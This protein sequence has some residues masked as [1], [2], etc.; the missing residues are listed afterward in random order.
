MYKNIDVLLN[1]ND[2]DVSKKC[3]IFST[4]KFLENIGDYSFHVSI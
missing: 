1:K 3:V 4:Q 2:L